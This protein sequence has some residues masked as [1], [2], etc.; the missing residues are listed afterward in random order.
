ML[1]FDETKI[2]LLGFWENNT[3]DHSEHIIPKII[4]FCRA[5]KAGWSGYNDGGNKHKWILG[6]LLFKTVKLEWRFILQQENK[7]KQT[8]VSIESQYVL[9]LRSSYLES[10]NLE[11]SCE[12]SVLI[13]KSNF[14]MATPINIVFSTPYK[15]HFKLYSIHKRHF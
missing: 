15:N 6:E 5:R 12:V 7:P 9:M 4:I 13:K 11:L 1:L 14:K 3:A 8:R 10:G 2:E